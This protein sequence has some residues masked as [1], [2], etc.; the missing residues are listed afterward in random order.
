MKRAILLSVLMTLPLTLFSAFGFAQGPSNFNQGD[1]KS[2]LVFACGS[3]GLV[4]DFVT[5]NCVLPDNR[6]VNPRNLYPPFMAPLPKPDPNDLVMRCG[7]MG[8]L[9]D[10]ATGRCM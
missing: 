2:A 7:A 3:K 1:Y 4:P 10:F 6:Q 5:G 8:R 9:P